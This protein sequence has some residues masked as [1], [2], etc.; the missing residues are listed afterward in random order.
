MNV[1]SWGKKTNYIKYSTE[2]IYEKCHMPY[3]ARETVLKD[4]ISLL[5]EQACNTD[6]GI[7]SNANNVKLMFLFVWWYFAMWTPVAWE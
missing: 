3:D 7:V 2:L 5:V 6:T 4:F 1:T